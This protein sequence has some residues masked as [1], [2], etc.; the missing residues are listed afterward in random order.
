MPL[1]AA[2]IK[3]GIKGTRA[4]TLMTVCW[5]Y[6]PGTC[7]DA[8]IQATRFTWR[9]RLTAKADDGSTATIFYWPQEGLPWQKDATGITVTMPRA[10]VVYHS[11]DYFEAQAADSPGIYDAQVGELK[12]YGR[13]GVAP[14]EQVRELVNSAMNAAR[15][16]QQFN[17]NNNN[18]MAMANT[19]AYR[20]HD[21]TTWGLLDP[22]IVI[23]DVRS[24]LGAG[25]SASPLL[26]QEFEALAAAIRAA[27]A[28]GWNPSAAQCCHLI[29][30]RCREM[31]AYANH[32]DGEKLRAAL[33]SDD[34][35]D[36]AAAVAK[37]GKFKKT[38]RSFT[39]QRSGSAGYDKQSGQQSPPKKSG[40]GSGGRQ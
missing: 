29:L 18:N 30:R 19:P 25:E 39:Q 2:T 35:D 3:D 16:A 5:Q 31:I 26:R 37:A 1:D 23:M 4:G 36:F 15:P 38:K 14:P 21:V 32:V 22:T 34:S 20:W 17:N 9:G 11:I 27:A 13:I 12:E 8:T 33:A 28:G 6:A 7:A 10:G 40:N 24:A